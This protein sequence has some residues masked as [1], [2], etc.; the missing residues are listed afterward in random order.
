VFPVREAMSKEEVR[1]FKEISGP[2]SFVYLCRMTCHMLIQ[3]RATALSV[4]SVAAHQPIWS[5][6]TF[7][8]KTT[9]PLEQVR[10]HPMRQQGFYL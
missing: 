2:L 7:C 4:L 3:L 9:A 1:S 10:T 5:L 6:W 8:S